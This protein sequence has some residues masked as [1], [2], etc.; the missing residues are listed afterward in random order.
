[1]DIKTYKTIIEKT[2][3]FPKKVDNFELAYGFLGLIDESQEVVQSYSQMI[4]NPNEGSLN[5]LIK[6]IG[7]VFWYITSISEVLNLNLEEIFN[8]E[9]E[10]F[11]SDKNIYTYCGNVKKFYRDQK[12]VDS[13]E[14]E[15]I[16]NMLVKNMMT[17][18]EDHN[19]SIFDIMEENFNKL[20]NRL[21]NNTIKG[22][23]DER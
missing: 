10:T 15:K 9:S 14:L 23:G 5:G 20:T 19:V 7:D 3:V 2:A 16:L 21:E 18:V 1:M 12:P 11:I 8:L 17:L 4:N 22:D 6:E 13:E